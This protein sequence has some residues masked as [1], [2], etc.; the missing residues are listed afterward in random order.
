MHA[1][2]SE[3]VDTDSYAAQRSATGDARYIPK[4]NNNFLCTLIHS[5]KAYFYC[6]VCAMFSSDETG[7]S[8]RADCFG[9]PGIR[10]N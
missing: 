3:V 1:R 6:G 10:I 4:R 8:L 5:E 9:Q 7:S 2:V